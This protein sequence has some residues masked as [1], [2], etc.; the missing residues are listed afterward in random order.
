MIV[1]CTHG[2][3]VHI[4]TLDDRGHC[5]KCRA[6]VARLASSPHVL[7]WADI[8]AMRNDYLIA[9]DWVEGA[10]LGNRFSPERATAWSEYRQF[11][12]DIPDIYAVPAHVVFPKP[13]V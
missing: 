11:L 2:H 8:R 10:L 6:Q 12:R 9:S 3:E 1:T 5:D 13:P 7:D 4:A